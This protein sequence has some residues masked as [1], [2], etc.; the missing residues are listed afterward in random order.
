MHAT[1]AYT[2][3]RGRIG[4][5]EVLPIT[6]TIKRLISAR[7]SSQDVRDQAVREGMTTLRQGRRVTGRGQ[8]DDAGRGHPPACGSTDGEATA[9]VAYDSARATR[10]SRTVSAQSPAQ[11]KSL[12]W[13]PGPRSSWTSAHRLRMPTL[14]ELFPSFIRVRRPEVILFTRQLATFVHVGMPMMEGLAVLRDQATSGRCA[15]ALD[16]MI[17]DLGAGASLSAAMAK[18]PRI[19]PRLYVDMIRS[20]EL[21]GQTSTTCSGSSRPT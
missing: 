12:L 16:E 6:D 11:V 7:A 19:F 21:S 9:N 1:D 5:F 13:D 10:L 8:P 20:A 17:H 4:V 18:F 14:E 15:K 3:Y 2:G